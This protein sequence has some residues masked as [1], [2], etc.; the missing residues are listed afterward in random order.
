MEFENDSS[1]NLGDCIIETDCGDID[2]SLNLQ[3]QN[4]EE[5]LSKNAGDNYAKE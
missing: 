1:M 2:A 4:L 3:L 5:V